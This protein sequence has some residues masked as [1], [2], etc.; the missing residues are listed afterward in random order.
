MVP[1]LD[2]RRCNA[3]KKYAGELS[4][5]FEG[6]ET[7]VEIPYVTIA[8][9]VT[10]TFR[11][12]ILEGDVVEVKGR[13]SFLLKGLCSRCLSETEQRIESDAEGYFF[14]N[15]DGKEDYSYSNG[16]VDLEEFLRDSVMFAL[17]GVLH[18]EACLKDD[19]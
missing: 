16:V 14:P 4:F 3:E 19:E 5:A 8:S 15:G 2:V 9:P 12:E 11:Y 17:P 1:K 13:L 10:G 7:L 6:D 18:C